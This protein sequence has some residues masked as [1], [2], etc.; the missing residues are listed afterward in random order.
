M[1]RRTSSVHRGESVVNPERVHPGMIQV[2][3]IVNFAGALLRSQELLYPG[4]GLATLSFAL[5]IASTIVLLISY[6][7]Q[8]VFAE[9]D[10]YVVNRYV[11]Y[12][13]RVGLLTLFLSVLSLYGAI[14]FWL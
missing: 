2:S 7:F 1:R 13:R 12:A 9:T 14:P 8:V 3:L 10:E 5:S 11:G 6:I 4:S